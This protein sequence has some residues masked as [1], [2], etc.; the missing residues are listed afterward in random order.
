MRVV[1]CEDNLV[2]LRDLAQKLLTYFREWDY[3]RP[4]LKIYKNIGSM[5]E[6]E[7]DADL[8][9]MDVELPDGN[10]L[11]AAA[12][13]RK[14]NPHVMIFII[15]AHPQYLDNAMHC[16]VFRFLTKPLNVNRLYRNMNDAMK[17]YQES[18]CKIRFSTQTGE[19]QVRPNEIICV[20]ANGRKTQIYTTHGDYTSMERFSDCVA[21]LTMPCFYAT[22][23]SFVVN[24]MYVH[25]IT[26][27]SV[28]LHT[29]GRELTAYLS[30][31]KFQEFKQVFLQY[32]DSI[33]L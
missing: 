20:E 22:H 1:I 10:G 16:N 6:K 15:T 12:K 28:S 3:S 27:N 26:H 18:N 14:Q 9:F 23:R 31:S 33:L 17:C 13:L 29:S 32:S 30:R 19:L 7:E 24:M 8:V 25:Q 4:E 11:D 5:L 21:A 2:F